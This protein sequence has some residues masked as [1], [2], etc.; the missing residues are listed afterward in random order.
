MPSHL[1]GNLW[2]QTWENI[3]P[4]VAPYPM[5][6][7]AKRRGPVAKNMTD[8]FKNAEKLYTSTGLL[9]MT[10]KFWNGSIF[11]KNE[12]KMACHASAWDLY[13]GDGNSADGSK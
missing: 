10:E 8:V 3:L 7:N 12:T 5:E 6:D 11:T 1:L 13:V 2:A 9:P 4:Q